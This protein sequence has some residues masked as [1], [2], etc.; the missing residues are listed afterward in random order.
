MAKIKDY[1]IQTVEKLNDAPKVQIQFDN[2][3][4]WEG[5]I[6][7]TDGEIN[8]KTLKTL[9]TCGFRGTDLE[10]VAKG[11]ESGILNTHK[12]FDLQTVDEHVGEKVITKV[13]WVND[14]DFSKFNRKVDTKKIG[15]AKLGKALSA[16]NDQYGKTIK[17]HAPGASAPTFDD[18][19]DLPF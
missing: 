18:K 16:L 5:F 8:Q 10:A 6:Y 9:F 1:G 3:L 15:G 13:E 7:K 17:N 19:E 12:D 2:G 4:W 14:P 11:P